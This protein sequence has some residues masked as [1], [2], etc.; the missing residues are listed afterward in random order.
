MQAWKKLAVMVVPLLPILG[1]SALSGCY[2]GVR[3]AYGADVVVEP[4]YYYDADYVDVYGV[5][6]PRA[7]WYYHGGMWEHRDFIPR[8]YNARVRVYH[9]GHRH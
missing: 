4:G 2:V 7:Y 8:G 3:P 5:F 9:D 6:H 1:L